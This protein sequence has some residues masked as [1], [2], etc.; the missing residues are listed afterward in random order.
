[1]KYFFIK[2]N[3]FSLVLFSEEV[4]LLN[5]IWTFHYVLQIKEPNRVK[6]EYCEGTLLGC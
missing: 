1:M 5:N 3:I 6:Y 2:L 4:K